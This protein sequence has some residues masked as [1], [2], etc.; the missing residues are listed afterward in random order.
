MQGCPETAVAC[1][2]SKIRKSCN[3]G[4][5]GASQKTW[6]AKA[7]ALVGREPGTSSLGGI[8]CGGKHN[9]EKEEMYHVLERRHGGEVSNSQGET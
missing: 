8:P 4:S 7:T 2:G 5:K 6:N 9:M 1:H 3:V